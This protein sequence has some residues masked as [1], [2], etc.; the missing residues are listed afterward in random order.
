MGALNKT[1]SC[2]STE[3]KDKATADLIY[4]YNLLDNA[5]YSK[6]NYPSRKAA[7]RVKAN[8]IGMELRNRG[9]L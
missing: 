4:A 7:A 9:V 3:Y 5:L 6:W 8:K 2:L 1:P